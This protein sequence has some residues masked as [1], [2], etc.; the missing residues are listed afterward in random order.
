MPDISMCANKTCWL[1]AGCYRN[2][3]SGTKPESFR[4]AWGD[5]KPIAACVNHQTVHFCDHFSPTTIIVEQA[6]PMPMPGSSW[7][8]DMSN[9]PRDAR[10]LIKSDPNGEI[11]AAQ[12]VKNVETDDEA[13]LISE[14]A[15][16][17]QNLCK[18]MAWRLIPSDTEVANG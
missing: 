1:R 5:F 3:A 11:F 15:G 9:A 8:T 16:G 14:A 7:C 12:W 13:W 17:S 18:A 10:I 4:Q 2:P 6:G